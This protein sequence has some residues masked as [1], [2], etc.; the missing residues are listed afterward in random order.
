[1]ESASWSGH[2]IHRKISPLTQYVGGWVSLMTVVKK[3]RMP[4]FQGAKNPYDY[5]GAPVKNAKGVSYSII[6]TKGLCE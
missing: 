6:D 4:V 3:N 5:W 1:M 2:F